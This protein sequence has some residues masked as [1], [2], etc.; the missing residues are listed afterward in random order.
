MSVSV[1]ILGCP[2]TSSRWQVLGM[3]GDQPL[4]VAQIA[5]QVGLARQNV[6]RLA[7]VLENEGVVE[8]APN[9]NHP[10]AKLV[11][12]IDKGRSSMKRLSELQAS[13]ANGIASGVSVSEIQAV[14]DN[15][16]EAAVALGHL[17]EARSDV[18]QHPLKEPAPLRDMGSEDGRV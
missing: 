16:E 11:C 8:Y 14:L 18:K 9:P 5:R 15:R 13:W 10:R 4:P 6:Q 3:I 12:L 7:D 2:L 17:R 1:N